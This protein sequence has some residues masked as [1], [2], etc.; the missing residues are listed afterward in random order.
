[1]IFTINLYKDKE[2]WEFPNIKKQRKKESWFLQQ[3]MDIDLYFIDNYLYLGD[4]L[5]AGFLM[6]KGHFE[7]QNKHSNVQLLECQGTIMVVCRRGHLS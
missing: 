3:C 7:T 5:Q 6:M 2:H 1:M 4:E